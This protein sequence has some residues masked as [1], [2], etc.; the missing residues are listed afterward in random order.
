[1]VIFFFLPGNMGRWVPL[2]CRRLLANRFPLCANRWRLPSILSVYHQ[3]HMAVGCQPPPVA[4]CR[5]WAAPRA[6]PDIVR[7]E[8][9]FFCAPPPPKSMFSVAV[10]ENWNPP[11]PPTSHSGLLPPKPLTPDPDPDS[12]PMI[13]DP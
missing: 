8:F 7:P 3:W 4:R 11:S 10:W 1:M 5:R 12:R 6:T 9:S 13:L 2:N